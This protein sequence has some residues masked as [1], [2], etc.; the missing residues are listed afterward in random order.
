[1]Q[2]IDQVI[3]DLQ[4]KARGMIVEQEHPV[5]GKVQ[6]ANIPFRFSDCD[7]TPRRVAPLLGEYNR[8]IA[9][10]L[11]FAATEIDAMVNDGVLY[12]ED[13]ASRAPRDGPRFRPPAS[14]DGPRSRE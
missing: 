6:A 13:A 8:E 10:E 1:M 12:A 4:V 9:H 2:N 3:A 5:L 14:G 7:V 11:G